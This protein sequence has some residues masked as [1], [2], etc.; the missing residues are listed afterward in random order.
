MASNTITNI[1][2]FQSNE[3]LPLTCTTSWQVATISN[4]YDQTFSRNWEST[5]YHTMATQ[6]WQLISDIFKELGIYHLPPHGRWYRKSPPY[7]AVYRSGHSYM[8]PWFLQSKQ[9]VLSAD[10]NTISNIHQYLIFTI[11]FKFSNYMDKQ[12][13]L[14]TPNEFF[15]LILKEGLD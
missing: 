10:N 11:L 15:E 13:L 7:P 14:N 6:K 8:F 1:R 3:N 9:V 2:H 5:T 4:Q 12:Y